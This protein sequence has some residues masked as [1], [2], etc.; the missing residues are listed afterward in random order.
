MSQTLEPS[1]SV[2][3]TYLEVSKEERSDLKAIKFCQI[4]LFRSIKKKK[5]KKQ[6]KDVWEKMQKKVKQ[7]EPRRE[8]D[9]G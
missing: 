3:L 6:E 1:S 9:K 2:R 7:T 8:K 4:N 5:K